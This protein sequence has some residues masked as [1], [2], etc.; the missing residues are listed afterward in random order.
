ME[1]AGFGCIYRTFNTRYK[2]TI[3]GSSMNT[4]L[5]VILGEYDCTSGGARCLQQVYSEMLLTGDHAL[6]PRLKKPIVTLLC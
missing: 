4:A 5:D 3:T 2:T 1:N 6:T